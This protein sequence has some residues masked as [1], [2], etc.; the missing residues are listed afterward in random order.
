ML[1]AGAKRG[2]FF[3]PE[4]NDEVLVAFEHGDLDRPYIVGMLWNKEDMPPEEMDSDG[5]NHIRAI[6]SR[7][8]QATN[9]SHRIVFD[10][11]DDTPSIRIEDNTGEN[12]IL[13]DS[14]ENAMTIKVKGDLAIEAGGKITIKA[15]KD[16]AIE[17]KANLEAKAKSNTSL[18]SGGPMDIKSDAK[19]AIDGSM[20]AE[21]T[22]KTVAVK[23]SAM[24]EVKGGL[25]KIN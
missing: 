20:S 14:K 25:V 12:Y 6:Y 21:L 15:E 10:D 1:M 19:V 24:T 5:K 16:I 2:T 18:Q 7:A 11:S 9:A 22:A 17:T 3:I 8:S 4:V 13:I 23:G